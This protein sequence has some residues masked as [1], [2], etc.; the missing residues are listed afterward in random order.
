MRRFPLLLAAAALV[1]AAISWARPA[2][3]A[4]SPILDRIKRT[5]TV[6]FAYREHAAPFSFRVRANDVRGYSVE[7]CNRV[8][9]SLQKELKLPA[10][11]IEWV[12]VNAANRLTTVA[13]G[14]ADI[15]CG[16]TTITLSRMQM[17]DFSV[18]IFVDGGSV[19]VGAKSKIAGLADLKGR[20][21]AVIGATTTER[22][23]RRALELVGA[24]ATLVVVKDAEEG[25]RQLLSGAVDGYA[26]DR[27]VLA[28]LRAGAPAGSDLE[29]INADFSYE[30]YALVVPRYDPDFRLAVNTALVTLYRSGDI[31]TIF[32]R[33]LGGL[34]RPGPLLHSMFY[35]NTLPE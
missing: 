23:L 9:A 3:A 17:V 8:A 30:P 31:D 13:G 5:G 21:V 16:T 27:I 28:G 25:L 4:E 24:S 19:L 7:L 34:G 15:E 26:G 20:R 35:L 22:S 14:K 18:P 10:L 29:L 11:K 12:P 2:A 33:W 6:T 32:Q 1:C